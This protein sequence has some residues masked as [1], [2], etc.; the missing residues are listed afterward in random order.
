MA[1][2][3]LGHGQDWPVL[4]GQPHVHKVHV[5]PYV[6]LGLQDAVVLRSYWAFYVGQSGTCP[7][8]IVVLE[9]DLSLEAALQANSLQIRGHPKL[10]HD[11]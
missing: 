4:V 1:T 11:A 6:A 10:S 2:T 5:Q 3:A 7:S 9:D 8:S